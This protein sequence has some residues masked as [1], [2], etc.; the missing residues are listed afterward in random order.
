MA[1][2]QTVETLSQ[3]LT[4]FILPWIGVLVSAIIAFMLKDFVSAF[5]KGMAF[6]LD[7]NFNEGDKVIL[8][9]NEAI[10]VKVGIKQTV[11]GVFCDRGYIWRYV[12][13]DRITFLNLAKI[14][15]SELHK[16]TD[17]DKGKR[18][19]NLIDKAQSDAI[20][21]NTDLIKANHEEIQNIKKRK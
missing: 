19:Q 6:A 20:R 5:A 8:D 7:K 17:V 10:I 4:A 2:I 11:F 15:D 21:Q 13:N 18:I 16:D 1:E 12:P 9:G 3:N 14:I